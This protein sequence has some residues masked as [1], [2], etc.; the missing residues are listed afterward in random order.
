MSNEI[1]INGNVRIPESELEFRFSTSSGPG[2]QHA[3]KAETKVTLLFDVAHSPSLDT[4]SRTLLMNRLGS[5]LDKE[6]V[7]QISAQDSR[8]QHRNRETAVARFQQLLANALKPRKRRRKTRPS[9][10]AN[11]RRLAEKKRRGRRKRERSR[12]WRNYQ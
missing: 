5:R 2:G 8:S 3:N 10:A 7:L 6:G 4:K 12:D 11:E 9:K 1:V